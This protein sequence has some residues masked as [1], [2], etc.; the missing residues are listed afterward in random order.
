MGGTDEPSN[1][2]LLTV[3]EHAEAHKILFEKYGFKEDELAWKGLL[4]L[5]D[6]EEMAR[7]LCSLNGKK[8][9]GKKHSLETKKKMSKAHLGNTY[10]KGISK[11][12][13]HRKKLSESKLKKWKIITPI[14]NE[15]ITCNLPLFC[16]ENNLNQSKMTNMKKSGYLHKGYYCEKVI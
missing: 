5:I 13:E 10:C 7:E 16:K 1:L 2:I 4:G 9:L 11:S 12:L 3:E 14:G 15:I 6:K 8:W